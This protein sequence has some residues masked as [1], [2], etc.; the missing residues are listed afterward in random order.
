MNAES[1]LKQFLENAALNAFDRRLLIEYVLLCK[2]QSLPV[3][4][5]AFEQLSPEVCQAATHAV[6][7]IEETSDFL[8]G[9]L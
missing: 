1:L 9:K 6:V 8:Q 4:Y 3:D 5:A 7:W 2:Q